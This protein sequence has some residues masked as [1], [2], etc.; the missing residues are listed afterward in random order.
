MTE[1]HSAAPV[2]TGGARRAPVRQR[3]QR[4][5]QGSKRGEGEGG[6]QMTVQEA[7]YD[8][9]RRLDMT[10][11]FGNLGSTEQPFLKNFPKDFQYVLALQETSAVA[12]ADGFSQVMKKPVFVNLHTAAGMGNGMCSIMTA[13]QNHTPL[14]ITAGQQTREMLLI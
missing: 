9:L 12:M 11:V 13:Y 8:L 3:P 10:T 7:T 2:G 4:A 5:P 1:E 14:V 6:T